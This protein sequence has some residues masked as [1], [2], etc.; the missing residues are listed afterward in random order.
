MLTTFITPFGRFFFKRLPFGISCAPEYFAMQFSKI[1]VGIDGLVCHMDDILVH[2]PTVGEHDKILKT[3][4]DRLQAEGITLNK[5]KCE[6]AVKHVRYLGHLISASGIAI[7]PERVEA[8]RMFPRPETKTELLRL[9]GM[10]N[11]AGKYIP[12]KSQ[13]LEPL[14]SLL[15][16][17]T[18]MQWGQSQND[19]FE[20]IKE[21]LS[22]APHLAFFDANKTII[23]SSDASSFGLGCCLMQTDGENREI[24]A[25]S[26]RLL[27]E[28]EKRYAQIEKEALGITWASEKFADYITGVNDLIFE[29]DHKPLVQILP[30]KNLDDLSIRLQRFRMRLMRYNYSVR[31]IQGKKLVIADALSR[32]PNT[33]QKLIDHQLTE[34]VEQFVHSVIKQIPVRD[35]F[36]KKI[37]DEQSADPILQKV[38]EFC[39]TSW[40]EKSKLML[41]LIPYYQ[42][43]YEL[44]FNEGLLVKGAR[45]VI[46]KTLQLECLKFIHTGHLGI[47]KC[48]DRAFAK[49]RC[50]TD[51]GRK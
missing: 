9:L 19:A 25:F 27:S 6:I 51:L 36:L 13:I 24:V 31:Y 11:F 35:K 18:E 41:E 34:V 42:Y 1:L 23:V 14:T 4:L 49:I 40:P 8:I 22:K 39:V 7:D 21:L 16:G 32:A 3:V 44:S 45:I 10:I 28:A 15:K 50:P 29:T 46:P 5:N 17:N 38:K 33:S 12:N 20:N 48:R 2:A 26:S 47:T 43:R 30:T 37:I